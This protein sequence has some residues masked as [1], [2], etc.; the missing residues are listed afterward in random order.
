MAGWLDN[1]LSSWQRCEASGNVTISHCGLGAVFLFLEYPWRA[2]VV[3]ANV[4]TCFFTLTYFP[5]ELK[6]WSVQSGQL[7]RN[8]YCSEIPRKVCNFLS[9]SGILDS[10]SPC[11]WPWNLLFLFLATVML[12]LG[13]LCLEDFIKLGPT[14]PEW[15]FK[16]LVITW[17]T[18][19]VLDLP[20][21]YSV[22]C[23]CWTRMDY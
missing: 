6:A 22:V 3:L 23:L 20:A 11:C 10:S 9:H 16:L 1:F 18:Y 2:W 21:C 14:L 15:A 5:V 19:S 7:R 13:S 12:D 4:A 8:H 17:L